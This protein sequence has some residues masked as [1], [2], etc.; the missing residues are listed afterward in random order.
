MIHAINIT[1]HLACIIATYLHIIGSAMYVRVHTVQ[2]V[3]ETIRSVIITRPNSYVTDLVTLLQLQSAGNHRGRGV[4][5]YTS[6]SR[7]L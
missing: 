7:V 3:N 4:V 6:T 1:G 2:V 5:C